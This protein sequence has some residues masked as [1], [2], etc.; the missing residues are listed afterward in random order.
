MC[1]LAL[2]LL[3]FIFPLVVFSGNQ[4]DIGSCC[5]SDRVFHW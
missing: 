1:E 4:C 5:K 2:L 3:V